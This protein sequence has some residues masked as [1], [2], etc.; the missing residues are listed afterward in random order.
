L[1]GDEAGEVGEPFVAT[2]FDLLEIL[3]GDDAFLHQ[4]F[5]GE[6]F[7]LQ[8]DLEFVFVGPDGPHFGAG[9][10]RNH[11]FIKKEKGEIKKPEVRGGSRQELQ[12]E[13]TGLCRIYFNPVHFVIAFCRQ[14]RV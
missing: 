13:L 2:G 1:A 7:D 4:R 3:G 8:P 5:A 12:T 14:V 9:V 11:C 6:E 10:A